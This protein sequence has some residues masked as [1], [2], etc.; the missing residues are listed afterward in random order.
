MSAF[1]R[2]ACYAR[3]SSAHA[4]WPIREACSLFPEAA[5]LGL[6]NQCV[7]E[8]GTSCPKFSSEIRVVVSDRSKPATLAV[9]VDCRKHAVR[10]GNALEQGH[11]QWRSL[12][13]KACLR[14]QRG[15]CGGILMGV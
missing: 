5:S 10:F 4:S 3:V 13:C 14:R 6:R 2:V 12:Y 15:L 8:G 11:V 9:R 7:D 1:K